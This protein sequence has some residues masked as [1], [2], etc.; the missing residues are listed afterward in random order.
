MWLE[1]YHIDGLRFDSTLYIRAVGTGGSQ[2]LPDGWSI[3]QAINETVVR[4]HANGI[5]IAVPAESAAVVATASRNG[6]ASLVLA[7]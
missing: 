3:L 7:T 4:H 1:E 6:D 2:E 5:T